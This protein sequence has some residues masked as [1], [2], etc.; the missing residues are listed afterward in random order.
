MKGRLLKTEDYGWLVSYNDS[1]GLFQ[2]IQL[3]PEDVNEILDQEK[4]FDNIEA[5]ISAYPYI[6]FEIVENVKMDYC[7]VKYA[8]IC[9][10]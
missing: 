3:H 5:R 6:E 4:I 10:K 2:F 8:K 9:K 7:V 1:Q